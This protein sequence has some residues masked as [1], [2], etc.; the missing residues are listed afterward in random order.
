MKKAIS[1]LFVL[2]LLP[3]A[4]FANSI[5]PDFADVPNGWVTDR[6][7]PNTFAN[8]GTFQ[9]RDNVLEIGIN[10]AQ[11]ISARPGAY[12]S[13]FYN[14]QGMNYA[15]TGG[16][17]SVLSADLWIEESWADA[18]KGTVRSDM[19]GVMTDGSAVSGYPIIGFTNYG[20]AARYRVYDGDV[21]GG[22]VDLATSVSYDDW[23][24]FAI[25]FTG[26]SFEFSINGSLVYTDTTIANT[27]GF[28]AA[29]MQAY[30]F[31]D[32]ALGSLVANNYEAR[33]SNT[34]APTATPEPG[35]MILMGV[36]VLGA[37]FMRRRSQKGN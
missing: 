22:W 25:L 36:G 10:R 21:A 5:M 4:G 26:T 31:F 29:I 20:G 3:V 37:V 15:L 12:Q 16:I 9:G 33:W 18:S 27:I 17:G 11:G 14:T 35:T 28:S 6:Y 24:S 2:M 8:I 7:Q 34:P 1:L 13:M 23:T 32:P 30:N 19:W